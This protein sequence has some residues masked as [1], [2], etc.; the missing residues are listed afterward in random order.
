MTGKGGNVSNSKDKARMFAQT[1][2]IV[3]KKPKAFEL[4]IKRF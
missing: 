3:R 2:G 1:K 4:A